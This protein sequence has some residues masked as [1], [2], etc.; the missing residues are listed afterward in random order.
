MNFDSFH[1]EFF[2]KLFGKFFGYFSSFLCVFIF[3]VAISELQFLSFCRNSTYGNPEIEI[4]SQ[5]PD[6]EAET[7]QNLKFNVQ[8]SQKMHIRVT[9]SPNGL[10]KSISKY[11]FL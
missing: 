8:G 10:G 5:I 4:T 1:H 6:E 2:G 11:M 3:R 9:I 7:L